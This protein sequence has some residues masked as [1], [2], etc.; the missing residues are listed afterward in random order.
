MAQD[1]QLLDRMAFAEAES[2]FAE[3]FGGHAPA[4]ASESDSGASRFA[5]WSETVTP[6]AE[7]A[8]GFA[9]DSETDRLLAEA[10]AELRDESFS[11]AVNMLAEET[12]QAVGERFAQETP[13]NA[14]ERGRVADAHLAPLRFEARQFLD[15]LEEGLTGMDLASLNEEQ[16][17]EVLGR[18]EAET[19]ELTPAGEEFIGKIVRKA[20]QAVKFVANAAKK[21]AGP[22]MKVAGSLLGPVLSKLKGLI[23][24]LLQR[25]LSFAIGRLPAPL[26]PVARGLA[27][28]IKFE[29]EG[30]DREEEGESAVS[31]ANLSDL[32]TVA[33]GFDE[34]LAQVMAGENLEET[35]AEAFT[36]DQEAADGRELEQL[37]E[38]RGALMDRF[39]A[40]EEEG[41]APAIEQFV[42]ALLG[43]LRLG[44]NLIGRPKVVGFLAKYLAQ[45]IGRWVGPEMAG[46]LSSAIVDTGLRL[47]SLEAEA[48]EAGEAGREAA[49]P[50]ALAAVVE[51]TVRRL[52]EQEE[53]VFE[54]DEL[55]QL[56]VSD[57]FGEAVATHFPARFVRP[58]LQQAPSLGGTFVARRPRSLRTYRKYSRAPNVEI[59][60]Q[61]ADAL[62]TFGGVTLGSVLRAAGVSFPLTARLHIYQAVPGTNA[63]R[64]VRMDRPAM[65]G[66]RGF[67]PA[68]TIH[69]LTPA[70]AGMLLREPRLGVRVPA[71]FLRSHRRVAVGQRFYHLEPMAGGGAMAL[72]AGE[73][74]AAASARSRPSRAWTRIDLARARVL[75]GFYLSET[76]AQGLVAAVR[77]GRGT[78]PL[79]QAL[80]ALYRTVDPSATR[81]RGGG[82]VVREANEDFADFEEFEGL[83]GAARPMIPR[84]VKSLLRKRLRAWVLPALAKWVRENSEAFARAAAHPDPGVTIRVQL[85]GV[86][87]LDLVRQ[88]ASG[89][90]GGVSAL[91]ALRAIRGNPTI[92]FSVT[93][94]RARA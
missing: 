79:L 32:E 50:A 94:G 77:D 75:V 93:P 11:E 89:L 57:A 67:S 7:S 91:G 26:Q 44:I 40:G 58:A 14:A 34:A 65:A 1:T 30:G 62:P 69:P 24:P 16:L 43:A 38:A 56:A 41:L 82:R 80:M 22:V 2:P 15:R 61:V 49:A 28:K 12:E 66:G 8:E 47:I 74:G 5:A 25:V 72:P 59:T 31:P 29:S 85:T 33:E 51:D 23:N 60:A 39:R 81:G 87:G 54:N 20:K 63:A 52:A 9:A 46:Q 18:F 4:A 83:V 73:T 68:A 53:F 64:V 71:P 35:Q 37:A 36:G 27:S 17:D 21:V 13:A 48:D 10:L 78:G 88:V 45:L 86:P 70:A 3:T 55:M 42:P 6:F 84:A 92:A 19:G 76:E 90:K